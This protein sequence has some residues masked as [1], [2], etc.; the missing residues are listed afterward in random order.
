MQ[1]LCDNEMTTPIK[2]ILYDYEKN[3]T[4]TVL[5]SFNATVQD[6]FESSQQFVFLDSKQKP[7]GK[8]RFTNLEIIKIPTFYDY[9]RRKLTNLRGI[10]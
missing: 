3:K 6:L 4:P 8:V 2:I 10:I 7:T 5:G 1:T 9:L